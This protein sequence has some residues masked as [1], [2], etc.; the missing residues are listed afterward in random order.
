MAFPLRVSPQPLHQ[1]GPRLRK[2]LAHAKRSKKT[3]RYL[4]RKQL[5]ASQS[6]YARL[7]SPCTKQVA[8]STLQKT[9]GSRSPA[10]RPPR[11][12]R[13]DLGWT[14]CVSS[15]G[16]GM[17]ARALN[18]GGLRPTNGPKSIAP[19]RG[20]EADPASCRLGR[21]RLRIGRLVNVRLLPLSDS[22]QIATSRHR[23]SR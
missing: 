21:W 17:P 15:P 7:R 16:H 14:S 10:N 4:R 19:E 22:P 11:Y 8:P 13:Q 9:I 3:C 6:I 12:L 20:P 2:A 18:R 1:T 5:Q 23:T